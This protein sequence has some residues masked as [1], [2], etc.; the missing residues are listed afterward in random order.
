MLLRLGPRVAI[1]ATIVL[2]AISFA[3]GVARLDTY[4]LEWYGSDSRA[5]D[6][7]LGCLVALVS[8]HMGRDVR[9]PIGAVVV[10][11][12]ALVYLSA[13]A[14]LT[15]LPVLVSVP[16]AILVAWFASRPDLLAWRALTGTGRISYGLYLFHAPL[17]GGPLNVFDSWSAWPRIVALFATSYALAGASWLGVERRFIHRSHTGRAASVPNDEPAAALVT[18]DHGSQIQSG[19]EARDRAP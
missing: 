14:H 8:F 3:V 13:E 19:L 1:G 17:A 9:V 10:S 11:V 6:L 16:C 18:V 5:K 2:I 12:A 4:G 15:L 7:L